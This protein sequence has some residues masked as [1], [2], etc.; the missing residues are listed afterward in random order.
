M[1]DY[2]DFEEVYRAFCE[3]SGDIWAADCRGCEYEYKDNC[4]QVKF[5]DHMI[6][7]LKDYYKDLEV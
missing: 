5:K 1:I 3:I 2:D 4:E 6:T 7:V